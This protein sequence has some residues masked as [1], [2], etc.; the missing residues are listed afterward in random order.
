MNYNSV[1]LFTFV[2]NIRFLQRKDDSISCSM[3]LTPSW[4]VTNNSQASI[5]S[6]SATLNHELQN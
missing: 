5:T 1:F 2:S 6:M 3:L 4:T